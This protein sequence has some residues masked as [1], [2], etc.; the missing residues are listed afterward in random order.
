[1]V[2]KAYAIPVGGGIKRITDKREILKIVRRT[3]VLWIDVREPSE[4]DILFLEKEFGFREPPKEVFE[5]IEISSR[6]YEGRDYLYAI[7]SFLVQHKEVVFAEPVL[8]FIKGN[9]LIT[10]RYNKIVTFSMFKRIVDRRRL[11]FN[12]PDQLMAELLN[13][14]VERIGNRLEIIGK[15]IRSIKKQI[16]TEHRR[17][18]LKIWPTTTS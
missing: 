5:D 14:E 11:E 10:L 18:L 2:L 4:E 8:F 1:M 12:F 9:I 16:F 6:F 17:K 7:F 3:K 15:R 13:L